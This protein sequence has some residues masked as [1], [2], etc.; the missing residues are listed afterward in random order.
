MGGCNSLPECF[1]IPFTSGQEC[2]V[3]DAQITTVWTGTPDAVQFDKCFSTWHHPHDLAL[4][5]TGMTSSTTYS[6]KPGVPRI[7]LSAINGYDCYLQHDCFMTTLKTENW[8][9]V[10]LGAPRRVSFIRI[11]TRRDAF[12]KPTFKNVEVCLGNSSSY[13]DNPVYD[14]YPTAAAL[15]SVVVL[16]STVSEAVGRYL[17]FKTQLVVKGYTSFCG[18]QIIGY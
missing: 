16:G 4:L 8:L 3:L 7:P 13:V 15:G 11:Q 17:Q 6:S 2:T 1:T 9:R 5:I 10:D 12:S 14:T 18:L